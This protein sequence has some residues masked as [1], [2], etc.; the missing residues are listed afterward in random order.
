MIPLLE[1]LAAVTSNTTPVVLDVYVR[2]SLLTHMWESLLS[3]KTSDTTL[4]LASPVLSAYIPDY[5]H[6]GS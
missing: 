6:T 4:Q 2:W 5:L 1:G 3:W